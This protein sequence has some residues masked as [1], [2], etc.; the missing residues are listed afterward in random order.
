MK[1]TQLY[2]SDEKMRCKKRGVNVIDKP[3]SNCDKCKFMY[4]L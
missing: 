1:K 4:S 2:S 3:G